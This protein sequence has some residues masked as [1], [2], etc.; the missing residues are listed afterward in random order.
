MLFG[1]LSRFMNISFIVIEYSL[2]VTIVENSLS[3]TVLR[4]S[5][6]ESPKPSNDIPVLSMIILPLASSEQGFVSY[7]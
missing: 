6:K 2:E 4:L 5:I 1:S 7:L 3:A